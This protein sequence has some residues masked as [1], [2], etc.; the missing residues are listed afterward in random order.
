M[1]VYPTSREGALR[2]LCDSA[3]LAVR[4]DAARLIVKTAAEATRVPTV[5]ENIEALE[6][7]GAVAAASRRP[8][9]GSVGQPTAGDVL[10]E[11][12]ALIDAVLALHDDIDEALALGVERGFLDVPYCL[13]PDNPGRTRSRIEPDGRLTWSDTGLLPLGEAARR[14]RSGRV[15]SAELLNALSCMRDRY[16]A[17]VGG[18]AVVGGA[19]TL[20][21]L[22]TER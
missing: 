12:R 7:A 15:G 13:H 20:P 8:P 14:S 17:D 2:L 16:D 1:G 18:P 3:E 22:R 4:G 9:L 11:A 21:G 5:A 10:E 19:A 6:L